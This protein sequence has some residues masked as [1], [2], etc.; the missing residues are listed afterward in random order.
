VSDVAHG[1]LVIF[2]SLQLSPSWINV[3]EQPD[4]VV[5]LEDSNFRKLD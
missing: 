3:L 4:P 1:P 2:I 5:I